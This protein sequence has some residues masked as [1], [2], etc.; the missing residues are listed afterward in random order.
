MLC[1][2]AGPPVIN[3]QRN[4]LRRIDSRPANEQNNRQLNQLHILSSY[5]FLFT[6]GDHSAKSPVLKNLTIDNITE[7]VHIINSHCDDNRLKYLLERLVTHLHDLARET[8]LRTTEWQLAIQFLV[9][10]GKISSDKRQE[11]VLLS[12]IL[13]LSLLVDAIDHPKPSNS[14]EGSVLGPFHTHDAKPVASGQQIS[15]DPD[16]EP[17]LVICT[18]RDTQGR[19]I[20]GVAVD[21]WE[22]DSK[23]FYDVQ[24][25][26]R[27]QPDGRAIL[28]SDNNGE[29]AFQ[30]IVPIP[31]P[32]PDDGPV[33]KLLGILKR[34]QYRP[35]HMHFMFK[36]AGFDQLI[37]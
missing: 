32:I 6:M 12:D 19:P 35:A 20:P 30:A 37:T 9:A 24:Y 7:N 34:H 36:K 26:D 31:Y 33:G 28:E 8:R 10:A 29:F 13:G 5:S 15:C 21:V 2:K 14:T 23:G 22:T 16:G 3:N 1:L 17:L 4:N 25:S 18:T 27:S 11:L